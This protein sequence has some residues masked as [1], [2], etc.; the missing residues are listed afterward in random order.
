MTTATG[1]AL[2]DALIRKLM[3]DR[4]EAVLSRDSQRINF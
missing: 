4:V 3:D 2:D 1:K